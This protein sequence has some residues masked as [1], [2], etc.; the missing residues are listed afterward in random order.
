MK[1]CLFR[2]KTQDSRT[3]SKCRTRLASFVL[4]V[5]AST[6]TLGSIRAAAIQSWRQ[7][8]GNRFLLFHLILTIF[9]LTHLIHFSFSR[10]HLNTGCLND[11]RINDVHIS[12]SDLLRTSWT[13]SGTKAGTTMSTTEL[14]ETATQERWQS[15]ASLAPTRPWTDED[16]SLPAGDAASIRF[17]ITAWQN[18]RLGCQPLS[19]PCSNV[20]CAKPRVCVDE[21]LLAACRFVSTS[22]LLSLLFLSHHLS[23]SKHFLFSSLAFVSGVC[24]VEYTHLANSEAY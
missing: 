2:I 24:K 22:N 9:K 15:T 12:L 7:H 3:F 5:L 6:Q 21:W 8:V 11:L 19:S 14:V 18:V 4:S 23:Q 16:S 1:T 17:S 10:T 13:S 20:H